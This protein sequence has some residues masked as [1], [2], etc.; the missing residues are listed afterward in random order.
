M[1]EA[2]LWIDDVP[3]PITAGETLY[4][5]ITRHL[6]PDAVPVLCHDPALKPVG[7]CRMCTVEVAASADAPRTMRAA[8]HTPAANGAR[9]WLESEAVVRLRRGILELLAADLPADAFQPRGNE[10]ANPLQ[11]LMARYFVTGSRFPASDALPRLDDSHPYLRFDA[12][13]CILC[14][15]CVRACDEVQGQFALAVAGRGFNS[16]I[17]RGLDEDFLRSDC[18]SC[19]RCVQTCPSNALTDRYRSQQIAADIRVRTTCTYCGVGC[20]LEV[21]VNRGRV[22]GMNAPEDAAVNHGHTCVKG[23]YAFE[24]VHHPERLTTPLIRRD[25]ELQP[26]TWDDAYDHI[27]ERLQAI[28]VENGADAVAGISSARCTN[29]ENYLMQKFM[30]VV[31]GS[32][33]I[34]G[35]ARVCHAPTAFG[36]RATVGTGAATNSLDDIEHTDCLLV[37][38]ANPTAAHPVT[39]ARIRQKALKGTPL[40]V[41]DPRRTELATIADIHLQVRP[42]GN[43]PL[44]QMLLYWILSDRLEDAEFIAARTEGFDAF[45]LR[46][47]ALDPEQLS[48]QC[49]VPA[50][51]ARAAAQLY[52]GAANAMA[53]HG[54]GVTEHYQGSRAVMLVAALA[55]TTGN[56]GR[57]GVGINPLRG[58]NNVQGAADMGVQ[59][60]LGPGYLDV[61]DPVARAHYAAHWGR[62][63]AANHGL[64][65]PEM[66]R[67]AR[68]NRLR[69]LWIIGEDVMQTDPNSCEVAYSLSRLDFL[70]VQ[71][72]FMTETAAIADVVLPAASHLEKD[73]TFTNGE[74][75]IQR[76]QRAIAPLPGCKTD[77]QIIVDIMN[78]MGYPQAGYDA[79]LH[80]EEIARVVPFFAGV[81][82]ERLGEDGLQWPVAAD[83]TG[84]AI[85]H[86]HSFPDGRA[87][88]VFEAF[89]LTPELTENTADFPYVLTTGRILQHYNCGTMTRR[90]PNAEL[91]ARDTLLIHPSD[92]EKQ[93]IKDGDRVEIRSR[94]GVTHITAK[95]SIEVQPGVLFTTFHFPEVAINRITSGV[96]DLD[97]MT[98]EYKVVAVAIRRFKDKIF[99]TAEDA[100]DA[101][102]EH[103]GFPLR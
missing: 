83:G 72:L 82:W 96:F 6:G 71:E 88:F 46:I 54:L 41:I 97:S 86:R 12:A 13:H 22:V 37:I 27:T 79:R 57:P 66:F 81:S 42:G 9:V 70:V 103:E 20:N 64:R 34:D 40:I 26:A 102:E 69:A 80:L 51:Q 93:G 29:E 74:R 19:G 17:V 23:R 38:G 95:L 31:I 7:A 99:F 18:V 50:G 73:G 16:R 100:E 89:R 44:L 56:I 24:Y 60:N 67:A 11:R 15:R 91:V 77:G 78:R 92:A 33:H 90:T 101:E 32:N 87:H 68:E 59:P 52:A 30:R 65:I 61:A 94:Q 25:G 98:P 47:M 8:C 35:C 84:T 75:R 1:S 85:L 45:R 2:L 28:I 49:G 5:C 53:F 43:L 48:A 76:V 3:Y 55:L 21:L 39:G 10:T 14:G 36:M 63:I 58:Q 4:Q 62:E